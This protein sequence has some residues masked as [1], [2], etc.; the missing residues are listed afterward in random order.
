M[1]MLLMLPGPTN[2]PD[3]IMAAMT[4]P[5]INHRSPEF[6]TLYER[7]VDWLRDLFKT[8]GDVFPLAASGTGAIEAAITNL[9]PARTL[10]GI[11]LYIA[12]REHLNVQR[13]GFHL[14]PVHGHRLFQHIEPALEL[15]QLSIGPINLNAR[16]RNGK[17]KSKTRHDDSP[18][19]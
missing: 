7:I 4:K 9:N 11:E 18:C 16:S 14:A 12:Q 17:Q 1:H 10:A 13:N 8:E 3:N 19:S 15:S 5:T 2:V 6:H